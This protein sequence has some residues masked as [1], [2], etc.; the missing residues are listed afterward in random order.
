MDLRIRGMAEHT[1]PGTGIL[2]LVLLAL[3]TLIRHRIEIQDF[4]K[5]RAGEVTT[6][7]SIKP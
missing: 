6:E 2:S 7:L 3:S 1:T 5:Y 4:R